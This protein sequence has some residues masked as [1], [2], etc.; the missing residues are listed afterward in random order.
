MSGSGYD[1]VTPFDVR[2]R[3]VRTQRRTARVPSEMM[4]FITKLWHPDLPDALTVCRRL[5]ININNQQRI[6]QFAAGRIQRGDKRV[7]FR[8]SCMPGVVTD[9]TWDLVSVTA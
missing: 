1:Q 8:R 9:K 4:Q 7:F 5:G 3:R 2:M 6:I